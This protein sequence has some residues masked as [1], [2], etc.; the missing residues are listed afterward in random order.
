MKSYIYL[1]FTPL[2]LTGFFENKPVF[3][4]VK[5]DEILNDTIIQVDLSGCIGEHSDGFECELKVIVDGDDISG[6]MI[7]K[8]KNRAFQLRGGLQNNGYSQFTAFSM[9]ENNIE[10]VLGLFDGYLFLDSFKGVF[11]SHDT[12][13]LVILTN[14]LEIETDYMDSYQEDETFKQVSNKKYISPKT[15]EINLK[16]I[17]KSYK[18]NSRK[19]YQ[20]ENNMFQLDTVV[21]QYFEKSGKIY[22]ITFFPTS[23]VSPFLAKFESGFYSIAI[24]ELK[25]DSWDLLSFKHK[26][27]G[28]GQFGS[29]GVMRLTY[30]WEEYPV[31]FEH[32]GGANFGWW[33]YGR[34]YNALTGEKIFD[35]TITYGGAID[36]GCGETQFP[37]NFFEYL[38]D[39]TVGNDKYIKIVREGDEVKYKADTVNGNEEGN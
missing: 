3:S 33:E 10:T 13:V 19:Q 7:N 22:A 9:D 37:I 35:L 8:S 39:Y 38:D 29:H 17:Y 24:H 4:T 5:S 15:L 23:M 26:F 1:L 25:N 30:F 16:K 6:S 21:T 27:G 36:T 18:L 34:Y 32:I 31:I 11:R 14:D 28:G 12:S 2:F 20:F